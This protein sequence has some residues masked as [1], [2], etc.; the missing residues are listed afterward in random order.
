MPNGWRLRR[1]RAWGLIGLIRIL[2]GLTVLAPMAVAQ[3]TDAP[4]LR[5][6]TDL[7]QI[8]TLV[9]DSDRQPIPNVAQR[10]FVVRIDGGPPFHV[11]HVRMEGDDPIAL[12]VLLDLHSMPADEVRSFPEALAQLAPN[13]L[14]AVDAVSVYA[15]DCELVRATSKEPTTPAVLEKSATVALAMLSEREKADRKESCRTRWNLRDAIVAMTRDLAQQPARRVILL[16]TDGSDAGSKST[17]ELTGEFAEM[18]GVAIFALVPPGRG[19]PIQNSRSGAVVAWRPSDAVKDL[20]AVCEMS[21]GIILDDPSGTLNR[22]L[23]NFVSLVR[24]RYILDFPRPAASAG[25]HRL[26]VSIDKM[27]AFIRPAGASFPLA[28][29]ELQ[30]DPNAVVPDPRQAPQVGKRQNR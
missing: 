6:Y 10:S 22:Q 26:E 15:L 25:M 1:I 5:V 4:I 9:L 17:S 23:R 7:V 27:S 11:T 12:S 28:D 3:D 21:G 29:P 2:T 16:I 30:K 18:S 20:A 8:P 14:H 24:G 13:S 19:V